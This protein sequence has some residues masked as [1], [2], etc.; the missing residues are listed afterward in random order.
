M[1][2]PV[3]F[4]NKIVLALEKDEDISR[5]IKEGKPTYRTIRTWYE[6]YKEYG[7]FK[8]ESNN[9]A[10]PS[11][12][13]YNYQGKMML[14]LTLQ[15]INKLSFDG[16]TSFNNWSV[17]LEKKQDFVFIRDGI[18]D[19]LYQ[20]KACLSKKTIG[21]YEGALEKLLEDRDFNNNQNAKCILISAENIT[22]WDIDD[23]KYKNEIELYMYRDKIVSILDVIEYIKMELEK[24]LKS[25]NITTS[26]EDIYFIL[27]DFIDKKISK[28]HNE[29]KKSNYNI[30]FSE[31]ID[32]IKN[33]SICRDE[34]K[35]LEIKECIYKYINKKIKSDTVEACDECEG[36]CDEKCGVSRNYELT[37]AVSLDKYISYINP[38][39]SKEEPL[40]SIF[41]EHIYTDNICSVYKVVDYNSINE[42]KDLIF[43]IHF[44]RELKIIPTIIQ[45][46]NTNLRASKALIKI[47]QNEIYKDLEG[48]FILSGNIGCRVLQTEG[49]KFTNTDGEYLMNNGKIVIE[50]EIGMKEILDNINVKNK[51]I[52]FSQNITIV[53]NEDL[54][55]Y[56]NEGKKNNL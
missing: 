28:Y 39:A 17:E 13:G 51:K 18:V 12:S 24:L 22:D 40:E 2:Y 9:D 20:V 43:F 32:Y 37:K 3:E 47:N 44:D 34:I 35:R 30:L 56:F 14:L 25:I 26:K 53:N 36:D 49:D 38:M 10:I 16:E 8:K 5:M 48:D 19:S 7:L 1:S 54:I 23:N 45:I 15:M 46:S 29:G 52:T 27:C 21:G 42:E 33:I 55:T 31:M 50:K 4:K 41:T 6:I 11:W